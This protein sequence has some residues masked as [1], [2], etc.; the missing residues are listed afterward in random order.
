MNMKRIDEGIEE[1]KEMQ[2]WLDRRT[3]AEQEVWEL[4]GRCR[5]KEAMERLATLD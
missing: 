1:V 2:S 3:E 5:F 4:F